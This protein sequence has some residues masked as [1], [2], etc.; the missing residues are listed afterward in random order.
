MKK[1]GKYRKKKVGIEIWVVDFRGFFNA[2]YRLVAT[3]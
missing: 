1:M 2:Q 3:F